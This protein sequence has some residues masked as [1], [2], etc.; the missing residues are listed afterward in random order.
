MTDPAEQQPHLG[1]P[2]LRTVRGSGAN[3]RCFVWAIRAVMRTTLAVLTAVRWSAQSSTQ[4]RECRYAR[5]IH[6]SQPA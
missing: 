3:V 4:C 1:R 6:Q 5:S 2:S